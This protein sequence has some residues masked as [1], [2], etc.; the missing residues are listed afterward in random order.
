MN[1]S[2]ERK[3]HRLLEHKL[4]ELGTKHSSHAPPGITPIPLQKKMGILI[5]IKIRIFLTYRT[6]VE[7][8]D[9]D[10]QFIIKLSPPKI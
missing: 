8:R 2:F 9:Y 5:E 7:Y 6:M 1:S 3:I 4:Q 10:K